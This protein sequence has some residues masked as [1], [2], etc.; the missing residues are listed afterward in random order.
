MLEHIKQPCQNK[1]K[2]VELDFSP[3][4]GSPLRQVKPWLSPWGCVSVLCARFRKS[5]E[6]P[7]GNIHNVSHCSRRFHLPRS[8]V[9]DTVVIGTVL[10]SRTPHRSFLQKKKALAKAMLICS[11]LFFFFKSVKKSL[12]K[13][14]RLSFFPFFCQLHLAAFTP[15]C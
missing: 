3:G 11:A 5:R 8:E 6:I 9:K 12:F 4:V 10:R 7:D 13:I 14:W 2:E 15:R 1:Q